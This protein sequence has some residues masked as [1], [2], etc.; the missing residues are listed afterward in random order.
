[1]V[2]TSIRITLKVL[3]LNRPPTTYSNYVL[4]PCVL[5]LLVPTEDKSKK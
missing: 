1:M 4:V 3:G 5:W 2:R